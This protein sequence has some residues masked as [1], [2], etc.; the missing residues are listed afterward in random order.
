MCIRDS[1]KSETV[2]T[3]SKFSI[4]I[5]AAIV[6]ACKGVIVPVS[7]THLPNQNMYTIPLSCMAFESNDIYNERKIFNSIKY[8]KKDHGINPCLLYTSRCV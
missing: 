2:K 1:S 5:F 4:Q 8:T 6:I 3:S 7:Y